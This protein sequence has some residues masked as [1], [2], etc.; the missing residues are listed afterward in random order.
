[1]DELEGL[2]PILRDTVAWISPPGYLSDDL[3]YVLAWVAL[4]KIILGLAWEGLTGTSAMRLHRVFRVEIPA[5]QRL[6]EIKSSWHVVSDVI[7]LYG[8]IRFDLIRFAPHSLVNTLLTFM[9]FY[10]WV[11]VWYYFTHRWMHEYEFLYRVHRSHHLTR[12]V[13]PL[14]SISMSWIEKWVF[15]TGAWLGFM[16]MISWVA[17]VTL[18]GIAAYY[19]YH[20]IISLHGHSNTEAS[21][22]GCL[23]LKLG[24]GSAASH[25]LHHARFRV[26]YGFSNMW[27]DRLLGTYSPD[28]ETLQYK[29]VAKAGVDTFSRSALQQNLAAVVSVR[30]AE[31]SVEFQDFTLTR[32]CD[33]NKS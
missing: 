13:T 15:Y 21:R 29:A 27:L 20:F 5:R 23:L 19:T 7:A 11:E 9:L 31:V 2:V 22:L 1:M 26:N 12:V 17:P 3:L 10:L 8:L 16:A 4:G 28:T 30:L 33:V 14:S 25:A 32:D 24:M 6:R 18:Y